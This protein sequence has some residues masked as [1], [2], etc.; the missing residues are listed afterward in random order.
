MASFCMN[1]GSKSD[2]SLFNQTTQKS[3]LDD[4]GD[5]CFQPNADN[6][7]LSTSV[8]EISVRAGQTQFN[9]GGDC[10]EGGY[11]SNRIYWQAIGQS[12][13]NVLASSVG[14]PVPICTD[15]RYINKDTVLD[16]CVNGRFNLLVKL[17]TALAGARISGS[18]E[19]IDLKVCIYG[20]EPLKPI[21]AAA[22]CTSA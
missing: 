21:Q 22:S 16:S 2:S 8:R 6:L 15:P 20:F 4:G 12:Q 18:T 3:C 17:P 10:N 9:V 13:L 14:Q 5:G 1:C 7:S 19:N 11:A